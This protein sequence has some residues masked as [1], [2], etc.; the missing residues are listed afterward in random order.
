M[1]PAA[2]L[3]V[4]VVFVVYCNLRR[5]RRLRAM[6]PQEVEAQLAYERDEARTW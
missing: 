6:T 2:A 5:A 4:A 1:I 3:V